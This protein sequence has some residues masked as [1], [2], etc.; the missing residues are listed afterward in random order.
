MK[1]GDFEIIPF[2]ERHFRLDGGTMFGVVPKKI[3]NR[4]IPADENNLVPMTTNLFVLRT[5]DKNILLDCGLGDCLSDIE[6]KIYAAEGDSAIESGLSEI[7]LSSDNIDFVFLSHLH[8]D[9]A[10]G[11][12][13]SV[14]SE[15][16]PRFENAQYI[17]QKQEWHD[18][19]NPNE[20]TVAVYNPKRFK[21][22]EDSGQL[23]L[24]DG[25]AEIV[26]GVKVVRTGGHTPGHQALEANS[27]DTTV[28][29]YADIL[30]SSFHVRIPYVAAV[31]L[32]PMRTM[33]VKK[34]L[35]PRLLEGNNA[36]AFDH[37]TKIKIGTIYQ[38]DYKVGVTPVE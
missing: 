25:D 37:D 34:E 9:H 11:A 17:T 26:P 12:V 21:P 22:L 33:A 18:A 36:V 10:G 24:V 38:K 7:G 2:I 32:D 14:N 13:K 4:L 6:K 19:L 1:F 20:R 35:I 28:V 27:G 31:D 29:Y 16:V 5:G 15:Y 30:P 23:Q 8:T 3:W